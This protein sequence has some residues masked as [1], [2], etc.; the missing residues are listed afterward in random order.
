LF[1]ETGDYV[2]PTWPLTFMFGDFFS[3]APSDPY[4]CMII[5]RNAENS[6][7]VMYE[8]WPA[9]LNVGF[10]LNETMSGHFIDRMWNGV[11]GSVNCAK[12]V[13]YTPIWIGAGQQGG[14]GATGTGGNAPNYTTTTSIGNIG[15]NGGAPTPP[16]PFPNGPDGGLYM[17]PVWLH[18]N[19]VI[20]GHL[21]GIWAPQH[22]TPLNHND[23]FSGMSNLV[24]RSFLAQ[25]NMGYNWNGGA[26]GCQTIIET[27]TTWS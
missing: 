6:N 15:W 20:R 5:G 17:S 23:T 2:N 25:M 27:S 16:F 3:T 1:T 21:K 19:G 9:L 14:G 10:Q 4:A 24:G 7:N 12:H 18:H 8:N 22:L 13:H 11:G 26:Q